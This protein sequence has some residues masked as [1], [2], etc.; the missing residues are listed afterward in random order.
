[1]DKHD[2]RLSLL[3]SRTLLFAENATSMRHITVAQQH[4]IPALAFS[5]TSLCHGCACQSTCR[6]QSL[7]RS[8]VDLHAVRSESKPLRSMLGALDSQ[9]QA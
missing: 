3:V 1:M 5:C 4:C 8:E 7:H 6:V 9:D 2:L